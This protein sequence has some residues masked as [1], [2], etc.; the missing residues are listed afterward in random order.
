MAIEQLVFQ[1]G[2]EHLDCWLELDHEIWTVGLAQWEGFAG[3]EIWINQDKPGEITVIVYWTRYEFWQSVDPE[4][5]VRT[6][7]TFKRALGEVNC[8]LVK[9][10][11]KKERFFKISECVQ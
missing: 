5:V 8:T 4:W 3:K 9:K 7:E 10:G 6:D 2:P 1:V 11:L